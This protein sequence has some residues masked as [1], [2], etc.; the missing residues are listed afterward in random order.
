MLLAILLRFLGK[1]E[2]LSSPLLQFLE[3]LS[4]IGTYI[5]QIICKRYAL[6]CIL[7]AKQNL[8]TDGRLLLHTHNE[9]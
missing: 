3:L 2:A 1:D 6:A 8:Q 5:E 7:H 4:S 9:N